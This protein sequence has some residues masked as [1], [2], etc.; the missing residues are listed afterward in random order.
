[1]CRATR[2]SHE[3]K[4]EFGKF[5][6]KPVRHRNESNNIQSQTLQQNLQKDAWSRSSHMKEGSMLSEVVLGP[7][8]S[9]SH[10]DQKP[11]P[12]RRRKK[13]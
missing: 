9:S 3:G 1:M 7:S 6:E 13:E 8:F 10:P 11:F 2:V 12:R 5:P 4:P